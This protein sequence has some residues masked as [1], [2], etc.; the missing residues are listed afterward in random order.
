LLLD[1]LE[2]RAG[3]PELERD[4]GHV[5]PA[6]GAEWFFA[7][8]DE[9]IEAERAAF[10][11]VRGRV[12]DIGAGAGRHSL[13]AQRRGLEA[14]A[15]DASPGAVEV[16]RRRGVRDAR[17]LPLAEVDERLG[18]FD[19][20]L[21]L[22]GNLGLAGGADETSALLERLHGLT[23]PEARIVFDTVDPHVDNDEADLAY[24]ARNRERGR[25]PGQMTIRIRYGRLA[26]PWYDL[27]CV[28][29]GELE[30]LAAPT[31][32]R[33]VWRQDAEPPDWYGVLQK[34]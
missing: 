19:T 13:E 22:C 18:V 32:W 14:V 1:H 31:G 29:P 8:P 26:T 28:S 21:L 6:M 3:E 15:I 34:S 30:G 23:A 5:G 27:L 24:L 9:W 4:D 7:E 2:G 10:E 12:L 33:L 25:M 17:L 16:C 11:R 20:V